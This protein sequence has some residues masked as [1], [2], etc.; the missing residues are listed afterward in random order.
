M[1]TV[2]FEGQEYQA[3]YLGDGAYAL[4]DGSG[5]WL[6]ANSHSEPTDRIY[7]EPEVFEALRDFT[8]RCN[9]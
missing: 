2:D 6:H 1:Q 5:V 4:F 7:L 3:E 8:R 9:E